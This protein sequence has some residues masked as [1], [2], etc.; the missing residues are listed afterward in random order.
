MDYYRLHPWEVPPEE[1]RRIQIRLRKRLVKPKKIKKISRIAAADVAYSKDEKWVYAVVAVFAY[2][3]LKMIEQQNAKRKVAFPYIPGLLTFREGPVLLSAFKKIR[4]DPEVT[5]F[6]GQG[7]A[8]PAGMGIATHLG[9]LLDKPTIGSAKSRLIGKY[10]EPPKETGQYSYLLHHGAVVGA[11]LRTRKNVKPIF[12]S[13][14]FKINLE[15]SIKII[16]DCC[17]NY[18]L[19]EPIRQ[20]H[21]L[22]VQVREI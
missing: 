17:R 22:T 11:V 7:I 19:P 12:V 20:V 8:H 4:S 1:A 5:I 2:P 16:L 10:D 15:D 21:A 18:R 14:G 13:P 9:I 3:S 6:D